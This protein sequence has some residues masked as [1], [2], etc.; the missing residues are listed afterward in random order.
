RNGL[1]LVN[2]NSRPPLNTPNWLIAKSSDDINGPILLSDHYSGDNNSDFVPIAGP[3]AISPKTHIT[4]NQFNK[5][6]VR[7]DVV[8]P[9]SKNED[10]NPNNPVDSEIL[11][12]LSNSEEVLKKFFESE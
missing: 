6:R 5:K 8:E 11:E 2:E 7:S 9:L 10:L 1:F 4:R 3:S 12:I